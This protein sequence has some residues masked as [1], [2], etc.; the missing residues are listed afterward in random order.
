MA[1]VREFIIALI[2][3]AEISG[4]APVKAGESPTYLNIS[5]SATTATSPSPPA[6]TAPALT[7]RGSGNNGSGSSFCQQPIY[8]NWGNVTGYRQG[9][10]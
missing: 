5:P 10:C 9:G 2:V 7:N 8:D 6:S 4:A 3:A 1:K